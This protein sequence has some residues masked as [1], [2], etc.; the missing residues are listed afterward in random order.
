MMEIQ[1]SKGGKSG[2]GSSR[3]AVEA[4]DSL[5]SKQYARVVD[6]VCEGQIRGPVKG[7]KSVYLNDTPVKNANG[8]ANFDGVSFIRRHGSQGQTYIP[9]FSAVEAEK[10]VSVEVKKDVPIVRTISNS[11]VDLARITLSIPALSKQNTKNGDINGASVKVAIAVQS[12]GGGFVSQKVQKY[13][14]DLSS[15][16]GVVS[17]LAKPIYGA[18][19]DVKWTGDLANTYQTCTYRVEYRPVSGGSWV[20]IAEET[21]KGSGNQVP[22]TE[23]VWV[24]NQLQTRQ[25]SIFG[26]PVYT[27]AAPTVT[28]AIEFEAPS[29]VAYEF[30][31]VKVSGSGSVSLSGEGHGWLTYDEIKGK[32][33][34]RYQR[35]YTVELKGDAPWDI[36]VTRVSED[37]T[38]ASLQ[39][40]TFF[41]S[42]TEIIDTKFSYPNSALM[43]LSIDSEYFNS[44]PVRS[45]DLYLKKIKVPS[46]YNPYTRVYSGV[47]DGTFNVKWTDN[48]AWVF[49]DL[50][51]N[52]RYGLGRRVSASQIDKW[53]LYSIAQYCDELVDDGF[54]GKEPRFTCNAYFQ[55]REPAERFLNALASV[56]RGMAYWAGGAITAVQDSPKDPVGLFTAANV[57]EGAF[58]YSGSA[59]NTRHTVALVTWN[60]PD[61]FYRPAV[62]YVEDNEGIARYGVIQTEVTAIGCT[63]RGQAHRFAKALLFTERMETET[64]SFKTGLDGLSVAPGEIIQ[65]SDPVRAGER[66]GGR[67]VTAT[68]DTIT[69]DSDVVIDDVSTYTLWVVMPDGSVESSTVINLDETTNILTVTPA[70]SDVPQDVSVWVLGASSLEPETWRVLSISEVDGVNAEITALSYRKDKYDAIENDISLEPIITSSLNVT[71]D[72]PTD[73]TVEESLYLISSSIVG[74][75]MTVSWT[76]DAQYYEIQWREEEGNWATLTTGSN[77]IDIQPVI[78]GNYDIKLT[79]V[80]ALGVRSPSSITTKTVYGLTVPPLDVAGFELTAISGNAH[81]T[82]DAATDLDVIVGGTVKIRHTADLVSPSWSNAVDIGGVVSGAATTTVLPL[83][84]GSYLAKFIDSTGNQSINE[85]IISTTA[86]S[87]INMN[88]VELVDEDGFAGVKDGVAD[89][90]NGELILDSVETIGD[91]TDLMSTW[92]RLSSLGGIA[93]EGTYLFDEVVDLGSVKTS[94]VTASFNSYAYDALDLIGERGLVSEWLSVEGALIDDVNITLY[95]S[96]SQDNVE[97]DDY[98]TLTLGDYTARAFKFKAVF[99]SESTTHNIALT[100]VNISIDMPDLVNS[101]D[102]I[103]SGAAVKSITFADKFMVTPAIGITAQNMQTGDCLKVTNKT[104]TG[105]DIE[106]KNSSGTTIDRT[107]DYFARAY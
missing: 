49:Y 11:E 53:A 88:A 95:V 78:A 63:S 52:D 84:Q 48:P 82:W 42:Y 64:V 28:E 85:I 87:I 30:R 57:I 106:F 33:K 29:D 12:N 22:K 14:F 41:D 54:G 26:R 58:S 65:T 21:V 72:V 92:P 67:I 46:N 47:W 74:T 31:I 16:S 90:G 71:P 8:S 43:A 56:F 96:T 76:G 44:I 3:V 17:S 103:A 100:G 39:N 83:L 35:S 4:E 77:S 68:T 75:R 18:S 93:G 40:R 15:G 70:Y 7:L 32:T 9:G 94:R 45:Y 51:V 38:T 61:D 104:E 50:V 80:N 102:D 34:S 55:K 36:R 89:N 69:L 59:A 25:V 6:L 101:V 2:G 1:G 107:F 10:S 66:M 24:F 86:P 105:F 91:Q 23:D 60:D 19:L 79:A 98:R 13:S 27:L 73:F 37:S 62:E 20:S 97:F 5:R 99:S 81:L